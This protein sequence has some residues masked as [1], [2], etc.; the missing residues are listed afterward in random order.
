MADRA[1]E[2]ATEIQE[3]LTRRGEHRS[4]GA[5]DLLIAATAEL[6][7]LIMLSEDRGFETVAAVTGAPESPRHENRDFGTTLPTIVRTTIRLQS[8]LPD[9]TH[10][11]RARPTPRGHHRTPAGQA[12]THPRTKPSRARGQG[13]DRL[14]QVLLE[15]LLLS[16]FGGLMGALAGLIGGRFTII[17][18]MPWSRRTR[19][20]PAF[21]VAVAVGPVLRPLPR[22]RAASLRSIDALRY[23]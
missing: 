11:P 20:G 9:P 17:G 14:G 3:A 8:L 5:V 2:R 4:A 16:L 6:H 1:F 23:E 19:C 12:H 15:A 7:Q 22:H 10:R 18:I 21:G 13:R